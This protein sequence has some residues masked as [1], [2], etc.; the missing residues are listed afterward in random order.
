MRIGSS[1]FLIALGAILAF[2][3]S[4]DPT[5]VAGVSIEWNVVGFI[6]L[7]VGVL[8]LLWSLMLMNSARDR[9]YDRE[10]DVVERDRVLR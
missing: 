4:I 3:M 10:V 2:A 6:L 1:I 9:G 8:G 5:P 7:A